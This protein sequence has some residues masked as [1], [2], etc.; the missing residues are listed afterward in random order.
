MEEHVYIDRVAKEIRF[1]E[2]M[3]N[4][5][6]AETEVINALRRE[7]LR[8]EYFVRRRDTHE[9]LLWKDSPAAL[10]AEGE[11]ERT[12]ELACELEAADAEDDDFVNGSWS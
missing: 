3:A 4:G 7:P 9:R 12:I 8:I 5:A 1:V 2:L 6:E 10:H 11:M